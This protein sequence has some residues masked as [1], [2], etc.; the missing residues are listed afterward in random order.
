MR[1]AIIIFLLIC[2][3]H[4][5]CQSSLTD[6]QVAEFIQKEMAKGTPQT[7]IVTKLVQRG[8]D[9]TQ[10][11]RVRRAYQR[12]LNETG[13]GV[14]E[15]DNGTENRLRSN[16]SNPD[17]I[18]SEEQQR[19]N[20]SSQRIQGDIIEQPKMDESNSDYKLY[21]EELDG[22]KNSEETTS[23]DK[24]FGRDIF[25]TLG[26]IVLAEVTCLHAHDVDDS[27]EI[28]LLTDG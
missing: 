9:I 28:L 19:E 11:R 24:V 5:L 1:K 14:S 18:Q 7:S 8:V 23:P 2:P 20:T 12:Q 6:T 17:N 22:I 13:L 16:N 26:G 4:A 3:I 25:N 15:K 21:K 27:L 10:I